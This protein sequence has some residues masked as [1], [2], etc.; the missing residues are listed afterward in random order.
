MAGLLALSR[1]IDRLNMIVHKSVMWLVLVA[2][3]VSAGNA[4]MRKLFSMSSNAFLEAQ[5]YLFS[6]V[7]LL[8][9][10]YAL[11]KG[12][13]VKI[14]LVYGRLS[15]RTQI[16]IEI[17]GTLFFLFPFCFI[18]VVLVWPV[19]A[20]KLATGETS[21]NAGG[22]AMWPVWMMIPAGFILLALQGLSELIK[23]FAFLAG[24]APDP[25]S[26]HEKPAH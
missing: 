1:A 2:I 12:E 4:V 11:Q 14:D 25:A 5:W 21:A 17:L 3:L 8:A 10:A 13:H 15:R 19:V 6:A 22:L 16:W 20:D 9:A 26:H 23:R 24:A 18:T 7:F